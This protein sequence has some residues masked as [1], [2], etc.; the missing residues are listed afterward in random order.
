[1]KMRRAEKKISTGRKVHPLRMGRETADRAVGVA[2]IAAGAGRVAV[3]AGP[4]VDAGKG[5]AWFFRA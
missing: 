1:M 3:A 2:G 5:N 4:A